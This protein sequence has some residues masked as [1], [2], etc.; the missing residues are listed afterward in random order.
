MATF[1]VLSTSGI[2]SDWL[3]PGLRGG[4]F[5]VI[6]HTASTFTIQYANDGNPGAGLRV[7]FVSDV[8]NFTYDGNFLP[9]GGTFDEINLSTGTQIPIQLASWTGF[10]PT[11]LTSFDNTG[12]ADALLGGNDILTGNAGNDVLN[13]HGGADIYIG[14]AGNDIFV[15]QGNSSDSQVDGSADNGS[16]GAAETDTIKVLP[17]G[18]GI[19]PDELTN[20]DALTFAGTAFSVAAF[21]GPGLG[22][23]SPNLKVT[24]DA[25]PHE[26]SFQAEDPGVARS[27]DLSGFTFKH[28]GGHIV[29]QGGNQADVLVG[30]RAA[31]IIVSGDGNDILTGGLGKDQLA[32]GLDADTFDFNRIADSKKGAAHRDVIDQFITGADHIDLSDID[33]KSRHGFQHF[34]FIGDHRFHHKQGELHFVTKETGLVILAGDKN[35]DGKA[36]FQIEIHGPSTLDASDLLLV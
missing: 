2:N 18:F 26:L 29:L 32:G 27:I 20:I 14:N 15:L 16:G 25:F 30:S 11:L 28:W 24:G 4:N 1:E 10:D 9:T 35:G 13:G 17:G 34:K 33:A 3:F 7:T 31:D 22:G 6:T 23:L 5:T 21:I 36:D 19:N 8:N 12:L